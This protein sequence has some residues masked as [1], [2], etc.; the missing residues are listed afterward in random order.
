MVGTATPAPVDVELNPD[1]K[2]YLLYEEFIINSNN[3][4]TC[5]VAH[6]TK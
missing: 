3:E 6:G 5:I 2:G 1:N 4:P